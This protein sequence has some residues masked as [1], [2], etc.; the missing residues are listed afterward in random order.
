VATTISHV[1]ADTVGW[2]V[3]QFAAYAMAQLCIAETEAD[4]LA[5]ETAGEV[6]AIAHTLSGLR[7]IP[8]DMLNVL[9]DVFAV[10]GRQP[11]RFENL[12]EFETIADISRGTSRVA[13]LG[14]DRTGLALEVAFAGYTSLAMLRS[15][16]AHR[17]IGNGLLADLRLPNQVTIEDANRIADFLNRRESTGDPTSTHYGAWYADIRPNFGLSVAY[18]FFVPNRLYL[19]GIAQDSGY[20]CV[21]RARWADLVLNGERSEAKPWELLA[22]RLDDSDDE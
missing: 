2:R 11:S 21:G 4:Y 9:E 14:A 7:Q 17:R 8:D 13:T 10:E 22:E 15:N 19:P 18:Q 1:H 16:A 3:P 6:A 12:F 5:Q 20:S